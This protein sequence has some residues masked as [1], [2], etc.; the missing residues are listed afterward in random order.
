MRRPIERS[1]WVPHGNANSL[2][3][4]LCIG[5]VWR[6]VAVALAIDGGA[7]TPSDRIHLPLR[8]IIVHDVNVPPPAP[9][10]PLHQRLAEVVECDGHLHP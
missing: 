7:G 6:G 4:L 9:G 3:Y 8:K 5:I 1:K 10:H 2:P